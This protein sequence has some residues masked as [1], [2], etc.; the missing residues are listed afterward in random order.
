MSAPSAGLILV[1]H[2]LPEIVP[3]KPPTSWLL[4]REGRASCTPLAE[5]LS[6]YQPNIIVTSTEPKANETGLLVS[7]LLGI[8]F[9]VGKGLHEALRE[10]VSYMEEPA[11]WHQ[12]VADFF[13][14]PDDL[15]LGEET[16]RHATERFTAAIDE[17]LA[18]H[19]DEVV[20]VVCHG[21]VIS[22]YLAAVTGID[23]FR[24]WRRLGLP[25]FVALSRPDMEI[26]ELVEKIS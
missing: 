11:D 23:P 24:L 2:A 22:L 26:I 18:R 3:G 6:A 14:R 17:V 19:P 5:R 9:E 13:A 21:T 4:S 8:P 12:A 1:K 16:A 15:I 7:E 20:V 10:T 25:S